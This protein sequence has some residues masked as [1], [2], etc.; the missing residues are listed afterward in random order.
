M[1]MFNVLLIDDD[2]E[3]TTML[4]QYLAREGFQVH[5]VHDGQSGVE[6]GVGGGYA[7]VVLDIMM[8]RLSGIDVLQ[9]I[10]ESSAV[11]VLS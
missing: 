7:I 11:P 8:P 5:A 1:A 6:E 2:T 3:L 10:R 9:R 4:A